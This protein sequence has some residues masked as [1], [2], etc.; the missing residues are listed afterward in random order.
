MKAITWIKSLSTASKVGVLG[1]AAVGATAG[2]LGALAGAALGF[3]GGKLLAHHAAPALAPAVKAKMLAGYQN[4]VASGALSSST[5]VPD[6]SKA[7]PFPLQTGQLYG[8]QGV[9]GTRVVNGVTL[10]G[11]FSQPVPVLGRTQ[12]KWVQAK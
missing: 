6:G 8:P 12:Y 10:L 2:P 5:P 11:Q 7:R 4:A 9:W 1:G 3:F